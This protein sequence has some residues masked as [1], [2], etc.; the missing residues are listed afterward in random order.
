MLKVSVL[1]PMTSG[2]GHWATAA[3]G[4]LPW[5]RREG[6]RCGRRGGLAGSCREVHDG[7]GRQ[8]GWRL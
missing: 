3:E 5:Q 4:V 1:R 7:H 2:W 8:G 6:E